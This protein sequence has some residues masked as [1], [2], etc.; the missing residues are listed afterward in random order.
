MLP[1]NLGIDSKVFQH[2]SGN[3]V[4]FTKQT[5]KKMFSADVCVVESLG[6]L[7]CKSEHF[8]HP[9]RIGN[10]AESLLVGP[11]SDLLLDFQANGVKIEPHLLKDSYRGALSK[12]DQP[13]EQVFGADKVVAETLGFVAREG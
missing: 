8:L 7:R 6:L 4:A 11:C 13:N 12:P 9:R 5:K 10:E 3:A 2:T 1:C